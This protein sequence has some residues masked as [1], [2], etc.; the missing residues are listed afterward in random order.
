MKFYALVG[1]CLT[2]TACIRAQFRP[3]TI[4]GISCHCSNEFT[5][6]QNSLSKLQSKIDSIENQVTTK[7]GSLALQTPD[8]KVDNFV[9]NGIQNTSRPILKSE[10]AQYITNNIANEGFKHQYESVPEGQFY[11]WDVGRSPSN[12]PLR[13]RY[14]FS[15]AY[16]YNRVVLK[17]LPGEN[18]TDYSNSN[19]I[20]GYK[21]RQKFIATQAPLPATVNDHWRMIWDSDARQIVM[22]TRLF[23]NN[24]PKSEKYWPDEGSVKYGDIDVEF[25]NKTELPEVDIRRFRVTR[26]GEQREIT[27]YHFLGWPD[28]QVP[29]TPK[30]LLEIIK[31][32]NEVY[33]VDK[34]NPIVVHC[35]AGVGRTGT[36]ILLYTMI[37]MAE[38][39]DSVDVFKYFAKLRTQRVGAVETLDQYI[40]V[41][42]TL[43]EKLSG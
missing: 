5:N 30:N 26:F 23:E 19:Y 15:K 35:T 43:Q 9:R 11:K 10:L 14:D 1:L 20:D 24:K 28:N 27:H 8:P 34:I 40:F 36:F 13:H 42:K 38:Q 33:K 3:I 18:K 6:V 31:R 7:S 22:L 41:H 29:E 37:D 4:P 32:T 39:S 16:D 21:Q 25:V 17:V 12:F 2:W